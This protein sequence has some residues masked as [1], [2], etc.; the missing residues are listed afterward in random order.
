MAF[1]VNLEMCIILDLYLLLLFASWYL[2]L[3]SYLLLSLLILGSP[4]I[5]H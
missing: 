5:F 1:L 3:M 2:L 4:I